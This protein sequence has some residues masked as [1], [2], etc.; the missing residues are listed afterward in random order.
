M[1][2]VKPLYLDS[3]SGVAEGQLSY[4]GV[5]IAINLFLLG[6]SGDL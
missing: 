2:K 4:T 5:F 1:L 3:I 6:S